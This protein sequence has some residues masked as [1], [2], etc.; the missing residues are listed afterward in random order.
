MIS[1]QLED[2][3]AEVDP[4]PTGGIGGKLQPELD[5]LTNILSIF[6]DLFGNVDWKD[7]DNVRS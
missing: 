3:N 4:V 2:E 6:N 1:I 7:A 5:L